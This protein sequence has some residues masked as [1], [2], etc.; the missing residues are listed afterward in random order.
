LHTKNEKART[1]H[2]LRRILTVRAT[3]FC[4]WNQNSVVSFWFVSMS[5]SS[6]DGVCMVVRRGL[7]WNY[8]SFPLF[9]SK[10][11]CCLCKN[12]YQP[13]NL[14]FLLIQSL[15]SYLQLFYLH[16]LFLI[17]FYFI[18]HS[19]SFNFFNLFLNLVLILLISICFFNRFLFFQFHL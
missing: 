11:A 10:I 12:S 6:L 8:F 13:F 14:L 9:L 19:S 3:C 16:W 15:F 7:A 18:F 17:Q 4:D 2:P 1:R 5:S